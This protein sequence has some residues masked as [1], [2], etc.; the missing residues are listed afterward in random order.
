M[1]LPWMKVDERFQ[2]VK[3]EGEEKRRWNLQCH[4][5][6][7]IERHEMKIDDEEGRRQGRETE[8]KETDH[9]DEEGLFLG[10][11]VGDGVR[12][13]RILRVL[14][15]N[16]FA[17]LTSDEFLT[18]RTQSTIHP[19]VE[20][21]ATLGRVRARQNGVAFVRGLDDAGSGHPSE[22]Q[23]QCVFLLVFSTSSSLEGAWT[24]T[25]GNL[26]PLNERQFCGS[27]HDRLGSGFPRSVRSSTTE[28]SFFIR[29]LDD[30]G[31]GHTSENPGQCGFLLI[32]F[33]H[34][35][36]RGCMIS[37]HGQYCVTE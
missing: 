37:Q 11:E 20:R 3:Q 1:G 28:R 27:R 34:E 22:N 13:Q 10:L 31:C 6:R 35:C 32:L 14:G 2:G 33:H 4:N 19:V 29:V 23:G 7:S 17:E 15:V 8:W 30:A 21:S 16:E 25:S 36:S 18:P 9:S 5:E 26:V 12:M 24:P